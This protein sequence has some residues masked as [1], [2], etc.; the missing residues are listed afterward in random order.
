VRWNEGVSWPVGSGHGCIGC[1]EPGFWEFGAYNT[2][3]IFDATPPTTYPPV[4]QPAQAISP[5]SAAVIAGAAGL[6]IGAAGVAT[7]KQ[8]SKSD[9]E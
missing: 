7:A 8:L 9:G 1:S 4:E 6:A 3:E 2:V 5:T